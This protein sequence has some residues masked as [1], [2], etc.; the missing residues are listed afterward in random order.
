M[1]RKARIDMPSSKPDKARNP[2]FSGPFQLDWL[3]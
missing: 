1:F 2:K 3:D